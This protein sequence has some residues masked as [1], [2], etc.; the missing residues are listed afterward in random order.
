VSTMSSV[1]ST[2]EVFWTYARLMDLTWAG[3]ACL[4]YNLS[5]VFIQ[6]T[7]LV[8]NAICSTGDISSDRVAGQC[9]KLCHLTSRRDLRK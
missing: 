3:S 1:E 5:V 7:S 2:T 8:S 6:S 9:N 4:Q